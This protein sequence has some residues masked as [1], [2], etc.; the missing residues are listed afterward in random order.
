MTEATDSMVLVVLTC[1][2]AIQDELIDWLLSRDDE[3]GITSCA[4]HGHSGN[5]GHLSIAEQVL[6][7]QSRHQIQIILQQSRLDGFLSSL[8]AD[9]GDIDLHYWVVPVLAEGRLTR[10]R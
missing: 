3:I 6:G 2:P 5:Y 4:V 7:R 1:S 10:S 8:V 9:H